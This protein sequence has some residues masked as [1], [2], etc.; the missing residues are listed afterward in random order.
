MSDSS[1]ILPI[2]PAAEELPPMA[3]FI[4][5]A[6]GSGRLVRFPAQC[7]WIR[8][9]D[10]AWLVVANNGRDGWL[11]GDYHTARADAE[12]LGRNSGLPIRCTSS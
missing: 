5:S 8:R 4:C 1:D 7:I 12:W 2:R 9:E 6:C 10:G 11:H 3:K